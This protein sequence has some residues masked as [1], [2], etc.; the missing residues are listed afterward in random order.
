MA[1]A[2]EQ[3]TL[4][5]S[6]ILTYLQFLWRQRNLPPKQHDPTFTTGGPT[7]HNQIPTYHLHFN[8]SKMFKREE[9]AMLEF[10]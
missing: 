5:Q 8:F 2:D 6:D 10:C 9:Q 1:L 4:S 3:V 7:K